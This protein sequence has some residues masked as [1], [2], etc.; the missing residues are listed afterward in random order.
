[1]K[2]GRAGQ[3]DTEKGGGDGLCLRLTSR[4]VEHCRE[5]DEVEGQ[6]VLEDAL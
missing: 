5:I 4:G 6:G 2:L 1:M 3:D